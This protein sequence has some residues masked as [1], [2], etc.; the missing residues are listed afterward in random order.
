MCN[1][2]DR[3]RELIT[4]QEEA[5]VNWHYG[6]FIIV[7]NLYVVIA[8]ADGGLLN[9]SDF[10]TV[11]DCWFPMSLQLMYKEKLCYIC[12]LTGANRLSS[13]SFWNIRYSWRSCI[14]R[15][16]RYSKEW[17][18]DQMWLGAQWRASPTIANM[19]SLARMM[20][21]RPRMSNATTVGTAISHGEVV[22]KEVGQ[23]TGGVRHCCSYRL[24]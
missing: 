6:D 19:I 9:K 14:R 16:I 2:Q 22:K 7:C 10:E 8:S 20:I 17:E 24:A 23:P 12:I 13:T 4:S 1:E 5:L 15:Y 18:H 11:T 3:I 21:I